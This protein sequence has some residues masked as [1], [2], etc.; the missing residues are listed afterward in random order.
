M[1]VPTILQ[2]IVA[3]KHEEV[4]ERLK[5]RSLAELEQLAAAAPPIRGFAKALRNAAAARRPCAADSQAT[6]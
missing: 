4:A 2:T 6:Q 1:S 5:Q 3:R